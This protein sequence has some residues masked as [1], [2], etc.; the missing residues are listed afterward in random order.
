VRRIPLR[1]V[2]AAVTRARR[3]VARPRPFSAA[4]LALAS[5]S[6]VA[7]NGDRAVAQASATVTISIVGTTDLHG[8]VFADQGRGGLALLGGYLANLRAARDADG[9]GV[10]LVDS[11]DTFQGGIESNLSEGAAVIDAYNALGYTALA[12]GNHDFEYGARDT[13][14]ALDTPGADLRGALKARAAQARFPFLAANLLEG[15]TAV[16]WPNVRPSA[17]VEVAGVR[18]GLVGV[19]TLDALSMTLAANVGGLTVTPLAAAVEREATALRGRGAQ[20]VIVVSHAG[21]DCSRFDTPTDLTSCD[22]WGEMFDVARRLPRGLVDVVMA[23]HTHAAVAHEVNGVAIAQAF[24]LGRGFARVD[25][26]LDRAT[27]RVVAARIHRPQDVCAQ[28]L[29]PAGRCPASA[30]AAGGLP[31][32]VYEGRTVTADPAVERAMAPALARVDALRATRLGPLLD[33][34]LA[35]GPPEAESPLGNLVA[36]AMREIVPGADAAITYG[37]GPGGLRRGLPAGPVTL[38]GLYDAFPF[39]NR[40]VTRTMTGRELRAVL[41]AHLQRPRW[42]ARTLGLSG[43]RVR[44]ACADAVAQAEVT[45][46]SGAPIAEDDTLTVVLSDFIAGREL[47]RHAIAA[48]AS[49]RSVPLVRDLVTQWMRRRPGPLAAD[50]LVDPQSPRWL[51]GAGAG[52]AGAC[53]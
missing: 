44:V 12:I 52:G 22:E 34:P 23:G 48:D 41:A 9:G 32:S 16:D 38:G 8:R 7:T 43:L 47:V 31:S 13:S 42:W 4:V 10:V 51:Y 11:G 39:D 5:T 24:S 6:I 35:N 30:S 18:V 19:M 3:H 33:T 40:V 17:I 50:T 15:G 49:L 37:T 26:T 25:L 20:I 46:A 36:E 14:D 21:G 1:V 28:A 29:E 53:Q 45:R 27:S 2:V